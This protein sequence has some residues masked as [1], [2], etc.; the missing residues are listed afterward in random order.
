MDKQVA[1]NKA[2]GSLLGSERPYKHAKHFS[3]FPQVP[4]VDA[5]NVIKTTG[6]GWIAFICHSFKLSKDG[7]TVVSSG[8]LKVK[9]VAC[10]NVF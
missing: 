2:F 1:A 3:A 10:K 8:V 7:F 9:E 4:R 5:V 6:S